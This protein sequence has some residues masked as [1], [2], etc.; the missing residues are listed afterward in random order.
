MSDREK[1]MEI[2]KENMSAEAGAPE[3]VDTDDANSG[4]SEFMKDMF[5]Q[6]GIDVPE[7]LS[8]ESIASMLAEADLH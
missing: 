6:D 7:S 2:D 4:D 8:K 1:G 5:E 3:I